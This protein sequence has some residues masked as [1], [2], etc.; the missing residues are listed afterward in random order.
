M[1]V[2]RSPSPAE[3]LLQLLEFTS[4]GATTAEQV[5]KQ[6]RRA[7]PYTRLARRAGGGLETLEAEGLIESSSAGGKPLES[8]GPIE[9][10]GLSKPVRASTLAWP[11]ASAAPERSAFSRFTRQSSLIAVL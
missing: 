11:Q 5:A 10:Q 2:S 1:A 8:L 9:L 4:L 6:L 7:H 3:L